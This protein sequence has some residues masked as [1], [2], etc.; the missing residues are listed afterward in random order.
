M[1]Q[2]IRVTIGFSAQVNGELELSTVQET[3]TVT[4]ESPL[5]DTRETGTKTT[6]DLETL[7]NIPVG[8]RPVGDARAHARHHDGPRQRRR[9]PVGSAVRLHLARRDHRQQQVV[10]RR[11][12]HHRHVG[13][14]RL[15]DA[16]TTSTCSRR[17][18]SRPAAP[19]STQQTGGVGINLV[20]ERHRP[21][22]GLGPL[23]RHRRQVPVRQRHR[24]SCARSGA[25]S[26][27]PIQNIK[28]YGFEVGGPI[29]KGKAWFWG[30]Y[31]TQDIKVGVVGFYK[32]TAGLP[33]GARRPIARDD[34]LRACLETDLH[35]R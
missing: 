11:R 6:F 32:N 15:A 17:C 14:R 24:R 30:S 29:K 7:Q 12:R 5:V 4:G 26:G 34:R 28:D 16:T 33:S 20:T 8:A 18:R 25:G 1:L 13:D 2:D 31:G 9:Q 22:Q 27:A 3:V 19:T 10:D 21:L 35:R 23:L